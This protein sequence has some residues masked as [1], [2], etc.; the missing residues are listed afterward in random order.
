MYVRLCV[1]V[2]II[3][4]QSAV[5][6]LCKL[7]NDDGNLED[8]IYLHVSLKYTSYSLLLQRYEDTRVSPSSSK[9]SATIEVCC[10]PLSLNIS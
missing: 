6:T 9:S 1:C 4:C 2:H 3:S 7:R 10:Q 5:A 8:F